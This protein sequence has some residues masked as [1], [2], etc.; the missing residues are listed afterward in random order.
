ML[1]ENA[2]ES[3][4]NRGALADLRVDHRNATLVV[5]LD[6]AAAERQA[7]TPAARFGREAGLEESLPIVACDALTRVAHIDK[8]TL[9][10]RRYGDLD[11]ALTLQGVERIFEQVLDH[12]LEQRLR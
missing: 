2:F 6:N 8:D 12:P 5:L 9:R 3:Y 4:A 7:Q 1:F 11:R 10:V